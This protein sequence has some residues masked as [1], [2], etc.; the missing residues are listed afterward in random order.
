MDSLD[1]LVPSSPNV[2]VGVACICGGDVVGGF[3]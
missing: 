3:I 2:C 1:P